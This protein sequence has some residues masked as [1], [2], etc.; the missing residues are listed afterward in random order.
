MPLPGTL[1]CLGF[2]RTVRQDGATQATD[3]AEVTL[4]PDDPLHGVKVSQCW[5][6]VCKVV[7]LHAC[8]R[9]SGPLNEALQ[10]DV[11]TEHSAAPVARADGRVRQLRRREANIRLVELAL[12]LAVAKLRELVRASVGGRVDGEERRAEARLGAVRVWPRVGERLGVAGVPGMQTI[13]QTI[14]RAAT[15]GGQWAMDAL[16]ARVPRAGAV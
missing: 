14:W 8:G 11:A 9:G 15:L 16:D 12:D 10:L 6:A 3:R 13:W 4:L 5:M 7:Q 1:D 2:R